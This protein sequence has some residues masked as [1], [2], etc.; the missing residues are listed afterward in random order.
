MQLGSTILYPCDVDHSLLSFP[1]GLPLLSL[2]PCDIWVIVN[3]LGVHV[4]NFH[5]PLHQL[6]CY[7]LLSPKKETIYYPERGEGFPDFSPSSF[8][9]SCQSASSLPL[10]STPFKEPLLLQSNDSWILPWEMQREWRRGEGRVEWGV[11][12]HSC[13]ENK[14]IRERSLVM[15]ISWLDEE[16]DRSIRVIEWC[17]GC[18]LRTKIDHHFD[19]MREVSPSVHLS[20]KVSSLGLSLEIFAHFPLVTLLNGKRASSRERGSLSPFFFFSSSFFFEEST[21]PRSLRPQDMQ[22]LV[23]STHPK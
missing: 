2:S 12:V 5:P 9:I 18:R 21:L 8:S 13:W 19:R 1:R 6:L 22:L 17:E 16:N 14:L 4:N 11:R 20:C 3:W 7:S 10:V 23:C 15:E